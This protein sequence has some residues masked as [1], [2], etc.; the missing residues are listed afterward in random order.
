VRLQDMMASTEEK[1]VQAL[2]SHVAALDAQITS[3]RTERGRLVADLQALPIAE[4]EETRLR[5][6]LE[7]LHRL[8]E[9]LQLEHQKA[10]MAEA[11][12]V[13]EVEIVDMAAEP[14]RPVKAFGSIK[15]GIGLLGGLLLGAWAA[16]LV[17]RVR[18]SIRR[19]D[20]TTIYLGVPSLAVI[21]RVTN[22]HPVPALPG[23]LTGRARLVSED[24]RPE[25]SLIPDSVSGPGAE[26]YRALRITLGLAEGTDPRRTFLIA[27]ACPGDGK[28]LTSL[29][30][31][32]AFA[33]DNQ[34]V[35]LVDCDPWHGRLHDLLDV[36]VAP[37]V[38]EV[39]LSETALD[40]AIR[41]GPV[42]NLFVLP[43]GGRA[44]DAALL[45]T[46]VHMR[47]LLADIGDRFDRVVLDSPPVLATAD[48]LVISQLV[49]CTV[50]VVRAGVT[51]REAAREALEQLAGAQA[52]VVGVVLND[53]AGQSRA[54]GGSY[55]YAYQET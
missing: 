45:V 38:K 30:L 47:Q 34:R 15:L 14:Y 48:A 3:A 51:R 31:A 36:S 8:D 11:V 19:R 29:H 49:D 20:E 43:R 5:R 55:R 6:V 33:S 50:F 25:D 52:R 39:L 21:P 16:F 41:P 35:L 24:E 2:A 17:E 1:L 10:R 37:G 22:P 44:A 23:W 42:P 13:G 9:E 18:P 32:R 27:S 54:Y 46:P 40:E 53:P 12:E 28:T 7:T 26:A 4:V